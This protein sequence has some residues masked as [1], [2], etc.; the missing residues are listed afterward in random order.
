MS[1]LTFHLNS[2]CAN[3][4]QE[5]AIE[6]KKILEKN[7]SAQKWLSRTL[8]FKR[9]IQETLTK[10]NYLQ[11][12]SLLQLKALYKLVL[13]ETYTCIHRLLSLQVAGNDKAAI[14]VKNFL[15]NLGFWLGHITLARNKPILLKNLNLKVLLTEALPANRLQLVVPFVCKVLE[16]SKA[17]EVFDL[18]NPWIAGVISLLA[19]LLRNEEIKATLKQE[20]KLLFNSLD[21][22]GKGLMEKPPVAE[23]FKVQQPMQ[24]PTQQPQNPSQNQIPLAQNQ[25]EPSFLTVNPELA[26]KFA[27]KVPNLRE[28]V[29]KVLSK[30]VNELL[31]PVISRTVT[32]AMIT[33]KKLAGK[34]FALDGSDQRFE[35]GAGLIVQNLAFSLALATAK[36]PL[37]GSIKMGLQGELQNL[38]PE[39]EIEEVEEAVVAVSFEPAIAFIQ[40]K[41]VDQAVVLLGQDS[42]VK[43]ATDRRRLGNFMPEEGFLKSLEILPP[44]LRPD[45][46]GLREEEI[47]VYEDF[48][49]EEREKEEEGVGEKSPALNWLGMVQSLETTSE[50]IPE[51]ELQGLLGSL[52]D[53]A[54]ASGGFSPSL[55]V[56]FCLSL[57]QTALMKPKRAEIL[58]KTVQFLATNHQKLVNKQIKSFLV[59]LPDVL[60]AEHAN[61]NE[62]L[63]LGLFN[64]GLLSAKGLDKTCGSLLR[65]PIANIQNTVVKTL[66]FLVFQSKQITPKE[67]LLSSVSLGNMEKTTEAVPRFLETLNR[68]SS[69]TVRTNK[70][71]EVLEFLEKKGPFYSSVIQLFNQLV[72]N[73]TSLEFLGTFETL[74]TRDSEEVCL[75]TCA[76]LLEFSVSHAGASIQF[77]KRLG[78]LDM[79]FSLLDSFQ[80]L[81]VQILLRLKEKTRL[82]EL[83]LEAF[84]AVLGLFHRNEAGFNSRPFGRLLRSLIEDLARE[85]FN[86]IEVYFGIVKKMLDLSPVKFPGFAVPWIELLGHHLL[87]PGVLVKEE[88][89]HSYLL[90]LVD[91]MRFFRKL[92][93]D[94]DARKGAGFKRCYLAALKI[95]LVLLHDFPEFLAFFAV[96]LCNEIPESFVQVRNIVLAAFPKNM[97]LIDPFQ[98]TEVSIFLN[99][100]DID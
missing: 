59:G 33:G 13:K 25:Q 63:L 54:T 72:A 40:R 48:S 70:K 26:Q 43:E 46:K 56:E 29:Q 17:S 78:V 75:R 49:Q 32:I 80:G 36:E 34:D 91:L 39:Q 82:L 93:H 90:L 12:I 50:E 64:A 81:L 11:L 61:F 41:V 55:T 94:E 23:T 28:I 57:L 96:S 87:V 74:L 60:L 22:E 20:I 6:L 3:N 58:L 68:F 5:K 7:D 30:S 47:R 35:R 45:M 8:V 27:M 69:F 19:E 62:G 65:K 89:Q 95:M 100:S 84:E 99:G 44:S 73:P 67:V 2:L 98:V 1:Q 37:R 86:A 4:L 85:E 51:N 71:T 14:Q 16:G 24:Q 9:V 97:R 42:D 79:D 92:L 38:L 52:R 53:F 66:S 18:H 88:L 31:N 21:M 83:F 77:T 76:I 10:H 15:K